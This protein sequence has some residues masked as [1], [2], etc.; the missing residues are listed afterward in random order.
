MS[1]TR[2]FIYSMSHLTYNG[3]KVIIFDFWWQYTQNIAKKVRQLGVYSEIVPFYD[4]LDITDPNIKWV[5]LSGSPWSVNQDDAPQIDLDKLIWHKPILGIC[6]GA[7]YIAHHL[8]STVTSAT[9][10]QYGTAPLEITEK[11]LL[12]KKVP[13][14][15]KVLMSHGDTITD[16]TH[17]WIHIIAKSNG[18]VAAYES[19]TY[20]E[21]I[22]GVQFHPEVHHSEY[23]QQ[24][25]D[26]FLCRICRCSNDSRTPHAFVEHTVATIKEQLGDQHCLMA[27]S[28]G[29]D[30]TVAATLIHRAIGDRLHCFFVDN[31][32]LRKGEYEQVLDTY[33]QI[34]L[35]VTGIDAKERFY[36]GLAGVTDPEHKRKVIWGLFIDVFD[37]EAKKL[38]NIS[39]LGQGTIYPDVIESVSVNGPSVTIKSHHNVGWLP[40]EMNLQLI[41]PLRFLFKDDVRQVGKDLGIPD[42]LTGR[43]P[44]PGPGLAIRIVGQDITAEKV[45]L[46]Q[47]A[48]HVFI[49]ALKDTL[50]DDGKPWYDHVRQAGVMLLPVQSVGVMGDERT[51]ESTVALRAVHSVDGMTASWIDFPHELLA[52]VSKDII[53][54]VKGINRVVYDIS[55]K[56]PATIEWE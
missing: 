52:K 56:P 3:E 26:N 13:D 30:S 19:T 48:D 1:F 6:Y 16:I 22:Y 41:E 51:Y 12:R 32:L 36:E 43:H 46:L 24:I 11:S 4:E 14:N 55:D 29:V 42:F 18:L 40:E 38:E 53:A 49:Q 9:H 35:N 25:L 54:K 15:S 27:I 7:Q 45:A 34:W 2:L 44:F 50:A 5:I 33:E 23:G 28:G 39:W 17:E 21:P 20:K 37:E 31:G 10:R 8:G 47:D